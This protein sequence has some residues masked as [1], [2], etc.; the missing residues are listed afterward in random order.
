MKPLELV[1]KRPA[2]VVPTLAGLMV[3]GALVYQQRSLER[4]AE[5]VQR[6]STISQVQTLDE[7]LAVLE[8]FKDAEQKRPKAVTL[9][10][11]SELRRELGAQV[12]TLGVEVA[13]RA[14]A[15]ELQ[16]LKDAVT[17]VSASVQKFEAEKALQRPSQRPPFK[18]TPKAPPFSVQGIELRSGHRFVAISALGMAAPE[19]I[20][21]LRVGDH[22]QGWRL[23]A[24]E[25]QAVLFRVDGQIRRLEVR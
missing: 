5:T 7:R 17:A 9:G 22:H 21:L 19:H 1:R 2:W 11:L 18:P 6:S 15:S 20:T 8:Q 12:T 25:P 16:A 10:Q 24:I 23:E 13:D 3:A 14:T 4:L